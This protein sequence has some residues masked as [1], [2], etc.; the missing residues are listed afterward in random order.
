[1]RG[2]YYAD[3]WYSL[4]EDANE[5]SGARA[6]PFAEMILQYVRA[7]GAHEQ[8]WLMIGD[9]RSSA[10]SV[11]FAGTSVDSM[12]SATSGRSWPRREATAC[13]SPSGGCEDH[14]K[15]WPTC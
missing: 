8:E 14:I 1:M 3:E 5:R 12:F 4:I 9:R 7:R 11:Y 13:Q 10:T 2:P 15:F 6:E